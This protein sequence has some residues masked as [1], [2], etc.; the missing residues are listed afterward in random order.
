[1]ISFRPFRQWFVSDPNRP[2]MELVDK[3][4]LNP[5]TS[6]KVWRDENV[7]LETVNKICNYYGLSVSEVIEHISDNSKEEELDK[8]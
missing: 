3:V 2:R 4:G 5:R 1:M 7:N 6:S 8:K